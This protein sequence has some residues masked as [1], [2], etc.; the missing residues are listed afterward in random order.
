MKKIEKALRKSEER[1]HGL[2]NNLEAGVVIH[3]PNT[4]I[5]MNNPR[6]S[7]LL[8]LSNDQMKGKE[9]IDPAWKF[10]DEMN[11]PLPIEDYPVNRILTCKEP[12]QNQVLGIHR[13]VKNDIIWVT[14]NGFPMFDSTGG[15]SEIVISF[16]DITDRKLAELELKKRHDNLEELVEERTT[17][18]REQITERKQAEEEIRRM[19]M[20]DQLTSLANRRQFKQRMEQSIKLA[21]REEKLLAMMMI[22]LDKFKP[23]NDTYGHLVGDALLQSVASILTKYSR[24]SDLVARL[25]GDEFAILVIHP[26]DRDG[27][28]INAKRITDEIKK[29]IHIQGHKIEIGA[30]IGIAL[31]PENAENEKELMKNSDLALYE[32]KKQ[33][34]GDFL[35]YH[36][37]M[38][39]EELTSE[40]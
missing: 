22:D 18:L 30:S 10:V 15:I 13:P 24:D 12:I 20:T 23:V 33:G 27:V 31:Y 9:A 2:L 7:E 36:P 29:P 21:N 32:I 19:A 39:A 3:A 11:T 14:V 34:G 4:S 16:I 26:E 37:D 17:E 8:G 38:S 25:G 40:R 6:A 1:F 35:F 28:E 5:V